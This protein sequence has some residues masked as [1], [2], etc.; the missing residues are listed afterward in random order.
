MQSLCNMYQTD[1]FT[2]SLTD[3]YATCI[4][5]FITPCH[6]QITLQH[7]SSKY[8]TKRMNT[9]SHIYNF[10]LQRPPICSITLLVCN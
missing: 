1:L 7:A 2:M 8:Y 6:Q 5:P 3:Y 10:Y 4:R 9:K